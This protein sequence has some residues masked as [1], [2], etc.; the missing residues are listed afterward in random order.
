MLSYNIKI[1]V[2]DENGTQIIRA[3]KED[4]TTIVVSS[5]ENIFSFSIANDNGVELPMTGGEGTMKYTVAGTILILTG[6][7]FGCALRRRERRFDF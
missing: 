7:C 4:G 3:E 2:T 1:T 5:A 6:L